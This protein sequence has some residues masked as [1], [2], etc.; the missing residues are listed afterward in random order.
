MNSA[1]YT[2]NGTVLQVSYT[3]TRGH[4]SF[5]WTCP[6][7]KPDLQTWKDLQ[8]HAKLV[9]AADKRFT[10]EVIPEVRRV[11]VSKDTYPAVMD[12]NIGSGQ[13]LT[14]TLGKPTSTWLLDEARKLM[15]QQIAEALKENP[16]E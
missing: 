2:Y 1:T 7:L 6:E 11:H 15:A 14:F 16:H 5:S 12:I 10:N 4:A 8:A 13:V 3:H 9:L